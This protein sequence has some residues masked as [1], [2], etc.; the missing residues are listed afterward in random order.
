MK[1]TYDMAI[2]PSGVIRLAPFGTKLD[3]VVEGSQ[4]RDLPGWLSQLPI[5]TPQVALTLAL[6]VAF[7]MAIAYIV[8]RG[9]RLATPPQPRS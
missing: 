2:S 3:A 9:T 7:A 8:W 1:V 5:G 6:L 4:V